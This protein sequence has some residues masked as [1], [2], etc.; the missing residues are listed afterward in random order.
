MA[1]SFFFIN[2]RGRAAQA[3]HY[4]AAQPVR[5]HLFGVDNGRPRGLKAVQRAEQPGGGFAQV[6]G[7]RKDRYG[8]PFPGGPGAESEIGR[9]PAGFYGSAWR[10]YL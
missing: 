4:G 7:G 1:A 8:G 5:G 9:A 6:A 10:Y 3:V 2:S